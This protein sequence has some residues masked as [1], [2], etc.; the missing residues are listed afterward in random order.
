MAPGRGLV[1]QQPRQDA[2]E[3]GL[4]LVKI[5]LLHLECQ[6]VGRTLVQKHD[7]A[8]DG[9]VAW[10]LVGH[11]HALGVAEC[12]GL[13]LFEEH[14]AG[15]IRFQAVLGLGVEFLCGGAGGVGLVQ[16]DGGV[17]VGVVR[18]ID[19]VFGTVNAPQRVGAG[20]FDAAVW[21]IQ[22]HARC[23]GLRGGVLG[24]RLAADQAAQ[25]R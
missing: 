1:E 9:Q 12:D 5:F 6:L 20:E 17:E 18:H 15:Q 14:G 7:D 2:A 8:Q 22:D 11:G 10:A 13:I 4:D 16:D 23:A 21:I 19:G 24:S 25:D 3:V